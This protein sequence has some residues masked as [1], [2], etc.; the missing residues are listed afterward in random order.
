M[1]AFEEGKKTG[2]DIVDS[3]ARN[4]RSKSKITLKNIESHTLDKSIRLV[5]VNGEYTDKS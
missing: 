1:R 2:Q 5:R 4:P 3:N